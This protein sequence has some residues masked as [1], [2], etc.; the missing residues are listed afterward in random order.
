MGLEL[1]QVAVERMLETRERGLD[2]VGGMSKR[3]L[4]PA[5]RGRERVAARPA[6][7]Q[8]AEG[9]RRGL[10]RSELAD[11][12]PRGDPLRRVI[13][14]HVGPAGLSGSNDAHLGMMLI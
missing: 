8:A 5:R 12:P 1:E 9:E 7:E 14:Q 13:L 4:A 6:L 3:S 2:T 11:Q 10:A